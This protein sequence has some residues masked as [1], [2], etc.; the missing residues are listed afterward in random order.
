M[1]NE[2]TD[3][4]TSIKANHLPFIYAALAYLFLENN[5]IVIG[6]FA[7]TPLYG[8]MA[9]YTIVTIIYYKSVKQYAKNIAK[10]FLGLK[11]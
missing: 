6:N 5:L 3:F 1:K 7:I 10:V 2:P 8:M 11:K 9:V 4:E